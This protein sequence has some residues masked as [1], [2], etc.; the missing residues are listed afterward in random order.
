[1][2][3]IKV[4]LVSYLNSRPFL[5]GIRH[6]SIN[7]DILLSLDPPGVCADKLINRTADVGLV[8]IAAI[9][10]IP[11][12]TIISDYCISATGK[13][14][15]VL[16]LSDVPLN[17]ITKIILDQESRTSVLLARI[18][19]KKYWK[20]DPVW[21]ME[22][23]DGLV[24]AKNTT[25]AVVIGDRALA[26]KPGYNY[27]YDLSEEWFKMTALPFVFACWVSNKRLNKKF[28]ASFNEALQFGAEHINDLLD[29]D[30]LSQNDK[31]Y[32]M[33][34]IEYRLNEKKKEGIDLYLNLIREIS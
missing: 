19:A 2:E 24:N 17:E 26:M 34:S 33:N 32:L 28:L 5:Y 18:L 8:P 27:I 4:S 20:I 16:L 29:Q 11:G 23:N 30:G 7:K 14:N 10:V 21:E 31:D 13:V 15:S 9:P 1:M 22:N 6:S 25:A 12:C 3:K